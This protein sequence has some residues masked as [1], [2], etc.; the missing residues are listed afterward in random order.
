MAQKLK[1]SDIGKHILTIEASPFPISLDMAQ[2][3]V[4]VVD[5]QN[6]FGVEGG[7]FQQGGIDVAPLLT[8]VE[9]IARVVE[10]TR[11]AGLQI[12][13]I[14]MQF[15][16]DLSNAGPEDGPMRRL[17]ENMNFGKKSIAPDGREGRLL[18]ENTWGTDILPELTPKEG[19]IIVSKHRYSAFYQTELDTILKTLGVKNLIVTGCTTSICVE[20]TVRDAMFRDYTCLLLEDCTAEVLGF[21]LP[22]SN[23]DASLLAHQALVGWLTNSSVLLKELKSLK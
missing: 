19:D 20:S 22:R 14:K 15:R 2:T 5:M 21:G 13:Y 3:A 6:D 4:L 11:N 18:I 12:I 23:Y 9:P 16:A 10:A 17:N 8:T 1:S 7:M